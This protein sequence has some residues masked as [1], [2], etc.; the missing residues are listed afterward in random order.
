VKKIFQATLIVFGAYLFAAC[1]NGDT[2][3][4]VVEEGGYVAGIEQ[5][6][7][8]E[9]VADSYE[10]NENTDD[11]V[12][13]G[14][15]YDRADRLAFYSSLTDLEFFK[16]GVNETKTQPFT[17]DGREGF[18]E[19]AYAFLRDWQYS[20]LEWAE[21]LTFWTLERNTAPEHTSY[22]DYEGLRLWLEETTPLFSF[23]EFFITKGQLDIVV[24]YLQMPNGHFVDW[25]WLDY[26][27]HTMESWGF[28]NRLGEAGIR[29][30]ETDITHD[31]RALLRYYDSQPFDE[32]TDNP[33]RILVKMYEAFMVVAVEKMI[34]DP[35]NANF[36][37]SSLR[38]STIFDREI[39]DWR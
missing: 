20:D 1:S 15:D 30:T 25:I 17:F 3:R 34:A 27:R 13:F 29:P 22:I 2:A 18:L 16:Q 24:A 10:E 12:A 38:R 4:P 36:S 35:Y 32:E 31:F 28:S 6:Y 7:D 8:A 14:Y 26:F 5:N 9:Y 21:V 23:G 19:F 39:T 33:R 11:I 37:E